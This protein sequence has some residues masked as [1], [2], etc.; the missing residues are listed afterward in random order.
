M[1]PI[2]S[3]SKR[4]CT[5]CELPRVCAHS[6]S[7]FAER[8]LLDREL[9]VLGLDAAATASLSSSS[10]S[11]S[12]LSSSSLTLVDR[13]LDAADFFLLTPAP[14]LLQLGGRSGPAPPSDTRVAHR[15]FNERSV[16]C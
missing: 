10:V 3:N 8:F 12:S 1:T 6:I 15:R 5:K 2:D 4:N 7:S 9:E 11:S 16:G 14:V 13:R